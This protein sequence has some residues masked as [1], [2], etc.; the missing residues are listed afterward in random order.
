MRSLRRYFY[1]RNVYR[2]LGRIFEV[3]QRCALG[4]EDTDYVAELTFVLR[5]I[6]ALSIAE[7]TVFIT[8]Y[9][10]DNDVRRPFL[11]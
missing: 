8:R 10:L 1:R 7:E 2:H 5:K 4:L 6:N 9:I 11:P 3:G